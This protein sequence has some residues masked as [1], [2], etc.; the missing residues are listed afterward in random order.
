MTYIYI[1]YIYH[2]YIRITIPYTHIDILHHSTVGIYHIHSQVPAAVVSGLGPSSE[3][4]SATLG[5]RGAVRGVVEL[6]FFKISP[7]FERCKFGWMFEFGW[8]VMICGCLCGHFSLLGEPILGH[9]WVLNWWMRF[10]SSYRL[11]HTHPFGRWSG[12][13]EAKTGEMTFLNWGHNPEMI[14]T[15]RNQNFNNREKIKPSFAG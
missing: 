7:F 15:W 10:L 12:N 11:S 4:C 13:F 5:N 1:Y 2:R 14:E 6:L 8:F 3:I 9:V